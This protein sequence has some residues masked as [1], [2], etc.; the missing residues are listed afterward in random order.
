MRRRESVL[1]VYTLFVGGLLALSPWFVAYVHREASTDIWISG[2]IVAL[3]SVA[4]IV[5]F[6]D[7]EEWLNLA[8]GL[9]LIASPWLLGFPHTKA[10]H[11][12]IGGGAV[13]VYIAALEL[14]LIHYDTPQASVDGAGASRAGQH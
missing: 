10:M 8:L 3:S 4:A 5:A 1:D 9:W 14:W 6:S 2:L 13:I 11:I 12:A 7:W